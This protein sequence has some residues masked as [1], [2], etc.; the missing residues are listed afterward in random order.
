MKSF[1]KKPIVIQ[2]MQWKTSEDNASLIRF[3]GHAISFSEDLCSAS[4]NQPEGEQ[5][6]RSGD[7]II[8]DAFGTL[9]LCRPE[10]FEL[11]YEEC[12]PKPE[13]YLVNLEL[14]LSS[15]PNPQRDLVLSICK[16]VNAK[17]IT[18]R[19]TYGVVHV[20]FGVAGLVEAM[21]YHD[22]GSQDPD[23]V[24]WRVGISSQY[25]FAKH[26][27]ELPDSVIPYLGKI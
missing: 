21:F 6:I 11:T 26:P 10:V 2:A 14:M 3:G 1:R 22:P 12:E 27:R 17:S 25:F 8:K 16:K 15:Y 9:D 24:K 7:W 5:P 13:D 19:A 23:Q 4:L 20:V 18:F